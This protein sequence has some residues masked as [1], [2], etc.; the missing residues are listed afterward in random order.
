MK[1]LETATPKGIFARAGLELSP[2][3]KASLAQALGKRKVK[4]AQKLL[5]KLAKDKEEQTRQSAQKALEE[6][7]S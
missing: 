1:I 6:L 7:K 4:K 2:K 5:S 3:M